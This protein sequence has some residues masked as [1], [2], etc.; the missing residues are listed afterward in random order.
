MKVIKRDGRT[1]EFNREKINNAVLKAFEEVD[2]E[3][4]SE[5][6]AKASEISLYISKENRTINVEE[7]QDIVEEKLMASKRKDVAKAF[8]IY[9]NNR[10]RIRE[11]NTKLMKDFYEKLSAS[12][13]QNQNANIDEK[14]FAATGGRLLN[15]S[16]S[17]QKAKYAG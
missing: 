5:A 8:I 12:N 16:K 6:K 13:V 17:R 3:I 14:S 10:S 15:G 4:T 9:R 1:V 7:I 11:S 2:K